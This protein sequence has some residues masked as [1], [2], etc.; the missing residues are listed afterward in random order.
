MGK[1]AKKYATAC[2]DCLCMRK[3]GVKKV[4]MG[5]MPTVSTPF[6]GDAIDL[7]GNSPDTEGTQMF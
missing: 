5:E 6:D 7:V 3:D 1:S 4:P 2:H